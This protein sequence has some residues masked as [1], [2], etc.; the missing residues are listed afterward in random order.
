MLRYKRLIFMHLI[1]IDYMYFHSWLKQCVS[2]WGLQVDCHSYLLLCFLFGIIHSYHYQEYQIIRQQNKGVLLCTVKYL[3]YHNLFVLM[4][5]H[6]LLFLLLPLA[7]CVKSLVTDLFDLFSSI[8]H[9]DRR[10]FFGWWATDWNSCE[11]SGNSWRW[12][13]WTFTSATEKQTK[14]PF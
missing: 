12:L 7:D 3:W 14:Q 10:R 4:Y 11:G 13:R 2:C 8:Q 1:V 9:I 5:F 6:T